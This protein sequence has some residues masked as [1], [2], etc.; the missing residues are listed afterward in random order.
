MFFWRG[1][2]EEQRIMSIPPSPSS[3]LYVLGID[4]R[5]ALFAKQLETIGVYASSGEPYDKRLGRLKAVTTI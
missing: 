5:V 4:Q 3:Y 1:E 2:R